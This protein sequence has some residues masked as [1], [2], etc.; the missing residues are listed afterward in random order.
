[1]ECPEIGSRAKSV[2]LGSAKTVS[3]SSYKL[4][5]YSHTMCVLVLAVLCVIRLWLHVFGLI[6]VEALS[7]SSSF[8][9][10]L[11][12]D[13]GSRDSSVVR[14]FDSFGDYSFSKFVQFRFRYIYIYIYVRS[15]NGGALLLYQ[16]QYLLGRCFSQKSH[17]TTEETLEPST[18]GIK[19]VAKQN[20]NTQHSTNS[21][22]I[23]SVAHTERARVRG[24]ERESTEAR[25]QA[26]AN[27]HIIYCAHDRWGRHRTRCISETERLNFKRLKHS[28]LTRTLS[29]WSG[30]SNG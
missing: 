5:A 29:V 27:S 18:T 16:S 15:E 11:S 6:Q 28:K 3:F 9:S 23:G 19:I 13:D 21:I 25:V 10:S 14:A 12:L 1:M 26:Q 17:F 22:V 7:E 4:L 20:D 24:R 2:C 8:G 30:N